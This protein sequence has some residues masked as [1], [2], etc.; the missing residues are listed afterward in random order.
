[1]TD[2]A[3]FLDKDGTLLVDVPYNVEPRLMRLTDRA[4]EALRLLAPSFRL[5]VISNQSG[6]AHGYFA[7]S[8]LTGV[9]RQLGKLLV[10]VGVQLD[11]FYY[12]PHHPQGT[13][14]A[15]RRACDCRKP[16]P[17]MLHLAA[18]A[19][20][21]DLGRSWMVGDILDDVE[22]GR[23]AGCRTV[24]IDNGG[25]TEWQFSADRQP[26][27][28]TGDLYSAAQH[29][30]E[31]TDNAASFETEASVACGEPSLLLCRK[32]A[33]FSDREPLENKNG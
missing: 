3:V 15:Y 24:L 26:D 16:Q 1:M 18:R 8:A 31:H 2:R 10:A 9:E 6:V 25:E 28:T 30:L 4:G 13:V 33:A 19:L 7:E 27:F 11:G 21:I 32:E 29:I 22:A 20:D 23:R 12:C 17:G 14:A 5:I